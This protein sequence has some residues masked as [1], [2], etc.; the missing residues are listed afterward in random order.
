MRGHRAP[1][2]HDGRNHR[3]PVVG[4]RRA[5]RGARG[6]GKAV[7]GIILAVSAFLITLATQALFAAAINGV[8]ESIDS[9][10]S[11]NQALDDALKVTLGPASSDGFMTTVPVT[12]KNTA[13]KKITG[14]SIQ[15]QAVDK[16][17]TVV[18]DAY[19]SVPALKAGQSGTDKAM[20]TKNL[21]AGTKFV[22]TEKDAYDW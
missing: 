14:G 16:K 22:I 9:S 8:S 20:F 5:R 3:F 1:A 17:G 21:P 10:V 15:I 18:D 13:D 12:V 2:S 4:M 11:A 19:V 7:A 6:R